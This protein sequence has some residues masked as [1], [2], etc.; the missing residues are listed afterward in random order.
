MRYLKGNYG[1]EHGFADMFGGKPIW[2]RGW[3]VEKIGGRKG[4]D[5]VYDGT[6]RE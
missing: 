3:K 2:G 5:R 1:E 6:C 4:S